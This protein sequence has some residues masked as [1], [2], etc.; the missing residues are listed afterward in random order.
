MDLDRNSYFYIG[1]LPPDIAEPPR[2]LQSRNF[3][4]CLYEL[5]IDGRKVG[6]WNFTTNIGCDGCKEGATEPIGIVFCCDKS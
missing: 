5:Y 6:L 3:A 2:Q 1:G 4:G